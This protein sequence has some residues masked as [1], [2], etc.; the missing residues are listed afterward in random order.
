MRHGRMILICCQLFAR[1]QRRICDHVL[2]GTNIENAYEI[3]DLGWIDQLIIRRQFIYPQSPKQNSQ[4]FNS[5]DRLDGFL[6]VQT[7][8]RSL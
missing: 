2:C 8:Q 7:A 6:R 4:P 1:A 5:P 3:K